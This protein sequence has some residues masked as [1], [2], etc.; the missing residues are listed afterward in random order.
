[1]FFKGYSEQKQNRYANLE[2]EERVNSMRAEIIMW[3]YQHATYS[4]K[5][6]IYNIFRTFAKKQI[7]M[8]LERGTPRE[9]RERESHNKGGNQLRY[10]KIH[11]IQY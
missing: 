5:S 3:E 7:Q 2:N 8:I 4:P 6:T 1:L 9:E 10:A 11:R